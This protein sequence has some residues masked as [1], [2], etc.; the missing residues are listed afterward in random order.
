MHFDLLKRREFITLLVSA[1]IAWL[2]AARAQQP[3]LSDS[4]ERA[5]AEATS[6]GPV[7]PLALRKPVRMTAHGVERVD[8]YAWLRDPNWREV[9]QDPSRLARRFAPISRPRTNTPTRC[10]PRSPLYASNWSRR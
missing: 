8:D 3:E 9:M 5:A 6:V 2:R 7:P 1:A 4:L 10:S